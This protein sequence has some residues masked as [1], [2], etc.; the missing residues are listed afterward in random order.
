M[1]FI[2]GTAAARKLFEE[3][4][5]DGLLC[6]PYTDAWMKKNAKSLDTTF[7]EYQ[8]EYRPESLSCSTTP[9]LKPTAPPP[10]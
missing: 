3:L 1:K 9:P 10:G 6:I 5:Q 7:K 8:E 4:H 2:G